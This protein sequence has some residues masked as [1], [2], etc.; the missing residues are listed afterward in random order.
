MTDLPIDAGKARRRSPYEYGYGYLRRSIRVPQLGALD[1]LWVSLAVLAAN[2]FMII[3][4]FQFY[5]NMEDY[6][7]AVLVPV[8]AAAAAWKVIGN[9]EKD[10]R[11]AVIGDFRGFP[12]LLGGLFI[13]FCALW[14]EVGLVAGGVVSEYVTSIGLIITV[15]GLFLCFFGFSAL[16]VYW[17]PL[18]YL[19]FL[20]PG[21]PGPP[22]MWLKNTLRNIVT[23]WSARTL[24][25]MGFSVFVERNVLEIPGVVLGI[26]DACSGIRSLWAMLAVAPAI[27]W[28]LR[29]RP[30][31]TLLFLPLGVFLAI[32]QNW[33][34]VVATALLCH[35]FDMT[36]AEGT[37]HDVVGGISFFLASMVMVL[38]SRFLA[39]PPQGKDVVGEYGTYGVYGHYGT[40]SGYGAYGGYG[41]GAYGGYGAYHAANDTDEDEQNRTVLS[42]EEQREIFFTRISKVRMGV[43][44][45]IGLM[46]LGQLMIFQR[47]AVRSRIQHAI[48]QNRMKLD[49][50]P[51]EVGPFRRVYWGELPEQALRVLRP[52]ESYVA[53]YTSRDGRHINLIINFWEPSVGFGSNAWIFPH[54]PD[55]CFREA[56]WRH[57]YNPEV[58]EH[59]EDPYEILYSRMYENPALGRKQMVLYWY[60]RDYVTILMN[61]QI[62]GNIQHGNLA[63]YLNRLHHVV[64][65]WRSPK[66]YSRFQYSIGIYV[67]DQGDEQ[68]TIELTQEFARHL[69]GHLPAF[70]LQPLQKVEMEINRLAEGALEERDLDES[71]LEELEESGPEEGALE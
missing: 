40:A 15:W 69:R 7:H 16:K 71:G 45:C 30:F 37:K 35:W 2:F 53:W 1:L 43:L 48:S 19:M 41:Y 9:T 42:A 28:F 58:P 33:I 60:N 65:S 5:L 11:P 68:A 27:A 8:I 38:L 66:D 57:D 55:V 50:F 59:L 12:I 29:L 21:L 63:G 61:E 24:E 10:K 4:L 56:G 22:E 52:S 67:Q 20:I 31:L 49:T 26:A 34:R 54:S 14:Y 25:I 36:W 44:L 6:S 51:G 46:F 64:N 13:Q 32:F 39:P 3:Q 23:V 17:F 47:Y 18:L 70:G 62:Q